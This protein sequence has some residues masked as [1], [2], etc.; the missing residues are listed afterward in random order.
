VFPT[1]VQEHFIQNLIDCFL[2]FSD[3]QRARRTIDILGAEHLETV[4]AKSFFVDVE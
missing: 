2:Q 3:S 1:G 4:L